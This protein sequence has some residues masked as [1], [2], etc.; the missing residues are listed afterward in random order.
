M[1]RRG[2]VDLEEGWSEGILERICT[3]LFARVSRQR[4]G[5]DDV[6]GRYESITGVKMGTGSGAFGGFLQ[7]Y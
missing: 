7:H 3:V 4:D 1:E 5:V 2:E 6:R